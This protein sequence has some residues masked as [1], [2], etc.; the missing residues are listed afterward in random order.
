MKDNELFEPDT[1]RFVRSF[2]KN[3]AIAAAV[4]ALLT[5]IGVAMVFFSHDAD[6]DE[7][8]TYCV[9]RT[10]MEVKAVAKGMPCPFPT[11][12]L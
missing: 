2:I 5:A 4:T 1:L 11:A 7:Q 8:V 6:A 3:L 12:P 9:D 10:T